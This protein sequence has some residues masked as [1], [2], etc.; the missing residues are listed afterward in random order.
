[1]IKLLMRFYDLNGGC[2][3]VDGTD[4]KDFTRDDLRSMFG[5]VLQDAW[6]ESGT[7]REN[8]RYGR[9]DASDEEVVAAAKAAQIDH[10]VRRCRTATIP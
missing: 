8:I 9:L 3:L 1:M 6:L 10:F 4:I 2:I 7:I 5:M